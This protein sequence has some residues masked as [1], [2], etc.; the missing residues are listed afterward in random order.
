MAQRAK[1]KKNFVDSA[2]KCVILN[3]LQ[4]LCSNA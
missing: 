4:M 3:K 1:L 2:W